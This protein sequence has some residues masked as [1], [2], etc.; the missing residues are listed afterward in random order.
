MGKR[1]TNP[2]SEAHIRRIDSATKNRGITR[3]FQVHFSRDGRL[4][5]KFF[6]DA[7]HGGKEKARREARK[8]RDALLRK[9]PQPMN[10]SPIRENA[11]GY[12]LRTRKNRNGT[13]TQYISASAR[14]PEGKPVRKAFRVDGDLASAVQQALDWRMAMAKKVIKSMKSP[15]RSVAKRPSASKKRVPAKAAKASRPR[16]PLKRKGR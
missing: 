15:Q 10:A 13:V 14:L 2:D 16:K 11:T 7:V 5:T 12:S 3:G 8:H 9:L 4:W 1:T 6:S